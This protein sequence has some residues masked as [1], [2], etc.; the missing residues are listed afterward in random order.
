MSKVMGTTNI[1][2]I[3]TAILFY[4]M[5]LPIVESIKANPTMISMWNHAWNLSGQVMQRAG[6]S[7]TGIVRLIVA[8]LLFAILF[9]IAMAQ[10]TSATTTSW[11]PAVATV[12]SVLTPILV[13]LAAALGFFAVVE[14]R[15]GI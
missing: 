10:I 2:S 5:V 7:E 1:N 14:S 3:V 6:L 13:A 9:P 4:T 11:N 12:F 15:G 8:F